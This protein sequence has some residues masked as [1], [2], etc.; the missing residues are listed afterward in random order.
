MQD[1]RARQGK[2]RFETIGEEEE[3]EE[4]SDD[5]R[6]AAKGGGR[7]GSV[8]TASSDLPPILQVGGK[9]TG[10]RASKVGGGGGSPTGREEVYR[11][12]STEAAERYIDHKLQKHRGAQSVSLT[13]SIDGDGDV[14]VSAP[15]RLTSVDTANSL[16]MDIE[17]EIED[18][19]GRVSFEDGQQQQQQQGPTLTTNPKAE[20]WVEKRSIQE[21]PTNAFGQIE[22]VNED[23]GSLKPSK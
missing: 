2:A 23:E 22:F 10:T 6:W 19:G 9:D 13:S 1:N 3:E 20:E 17:K 15:D 4:E 11:S 18:L 7:R 5:D 16:R 21:F 8:S 14:V 12:P